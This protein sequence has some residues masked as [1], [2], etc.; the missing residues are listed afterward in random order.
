MIISRRALLRATAAGG[1]CLSTGA[2]WSQSY[3]SRPIRLIVPFP[4]G[5]VVDLYGRLFGQWLSDRLRQP[6]IVENRAGGGGNV[7]TEAALRSAPDGY[8][9]LQLSAANSWNVALYEKL[10]FDLLRDITPIAGIYQA[11]AILVVHPSFAVKSVPELIA[12][13]RANPGKIDMASA[14]V[15]T[16]Q[17]VYGELFKAMTGVNMTHVPFRGGGPAMIDLLAGHVPLMFETYATGIVH[18]REGKLRALGVT[19]STRTPTLPDVPAIAEF[20]PGFEGIGWQGIAGPKGMPGEIVERLNR[21][22]NAALD[23]PRMTARMAD[24]GATPLRLTPAEF[25]TFIAAYT[26]KWSAIIKGAGAKVE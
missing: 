18:V 8:T 20:V 10:N 22:V 13:A 25:Q 24:L 15:G 11:P 17:H 23:D 4:A 5:G 7:G 2:A 16:A 1:A 26:G 14:G 21:E 6:V 12:Y 19:A 9:L 3:P